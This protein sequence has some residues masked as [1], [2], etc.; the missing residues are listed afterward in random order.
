MPCS[1]CFLF[2]LYLEGVCSAVLC[3]PPPRSGVTGR[4]YTCPSRWTSSFPRRIPPSRWSRGTSS[5]CLH[6]MAD[7]HW[8]PLTVLCTVMPVFQC[9]SLR[10]SHPLLFSIFDSRLETNKKERLLALSPFPLFHSMGENC[11]YTENK[12]DKL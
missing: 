1:G 4:K 11:I 2:A 12:N 8:L 3:W 5:G 7:S 9:Y 6:R 10:S